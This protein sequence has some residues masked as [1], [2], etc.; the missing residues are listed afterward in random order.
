MASKKAF[1]SGAA[2][3]AILMISSALAFSATR[4]GG[5]TPAI[6]GAKM[7]LRHALEQNVARPGKSDMAGFSLTA[8]DRA[9]MRSAILAQLQAFRRNDATAAFA[10]VAPMARKTFVSARHFLTSV[11]DVYK[12]AYKSRLQ[13]FD[14][15]DLSGPLPRQRL[16]MTSPRG[17]QWLASFSMQRQGGGRWQIMGVTIEMAPGYVI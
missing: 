8:S 17:E 10:H 5:M 4:P 16:L 2:F 12:M 14:G 11:Q 1:M 3:T 9:A 13:R 15:I 6:Q 7:G